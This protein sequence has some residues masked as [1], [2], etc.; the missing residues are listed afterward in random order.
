MSIRRNDP[1]PCGSGRKYK[2]CC[3]EGDEARE[4]GQRVA[5]SERERQLATGDEDMALAIAK[6]VRTVMAKDSQEL[7]SLLDRFADVLTTDP[8]LVTLRFD[9]AEFAAAVEQSLSRLG[10]VQGPARP[11]V[12]SRTRC[13]SSAAA[14][15]SDGCTKG[16]RAP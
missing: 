9:E 1:C 2:R 12:S 4:R 10:R 11:C 15:S 14:A 7:G 8:L 3:S 6:T 16:S 5:E 13:T